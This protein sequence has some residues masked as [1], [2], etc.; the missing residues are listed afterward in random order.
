M[1]ANTIRHWG[2]QRCTKQDW[3][4]DLELS[5]VELLVQPGKALVPEHRNV[6]CELAGLGAGDQ[7]LAGRPAV[8]LL[9]AP[10]YGGCVWA[11]ACRKKQVGFSRPGQALPT[12]PGAWPLAACVTC[13]E[14]LLFPGT[15]F[16]HVRSG[17]TCGSMD[18]LGGVVGSVTPPKLYTKPCERIVFGNEPKAF[19]RSS[20]GPVSVK[21]QL[22]DS[23]LPDPFHP[24]ALLLEA[25]VP[26]HL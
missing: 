17:T 26:P 19:L 24:T 11:R 1:T 20:K 12:S 22:L 5:Q 25:L 14:A 21:R 18:G 23:K 2:F 7:R 3:T 10:Q 15:W 6:L 16:P 13:G 8:G 4:S 9:R